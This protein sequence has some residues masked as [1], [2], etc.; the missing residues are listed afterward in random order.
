MG[1]EG[2]WGPAGPEE[3]PE[4]V[5]ET[6]ARGGP[7]LGLRQR[8]TSR[9]F[10][11][12][13]GGPRS[14]SLFSCPNGHHADTRWPSGPSGTQRRGCYE[15]V[16]KRSAPLPGWGRRREQRSHPRLPAGSRSPAHGKNQRK[17]RGGHAARTD[18]DVDSRQAQSVIHVGRVAGARLEAVK[19]FPRGNSARPDPS[20]LRADVS[21][22]ALLLLNVP[23]G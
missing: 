18:G 15:A 7:A 8:E 17:R 14:V 5:M 2:S 9:W 10:L 13:L 21:H 3:K 16:I 12:P 4:A 20:G 11:V 22:E 23:S 1:Q 6:S 19:A